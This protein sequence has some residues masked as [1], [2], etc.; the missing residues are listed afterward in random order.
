MGGPRNNGCTEAVPLG[1]QG[2]VCS[3]FRQPAINL[4]SSAFPL[5]SLCLQLGLM[6]VSSVSAPTA[7]TPLSLRFNLTWLDESEVTISRDD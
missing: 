2:Q 4:A 7:R 3:A 5:P 1:T 6:N